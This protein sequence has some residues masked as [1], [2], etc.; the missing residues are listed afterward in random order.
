MLGS[1]YDKFRSCLRQTR[2][3]EDY[4]GFRTPMLRRD[5]WSQNQGILCIKICVVED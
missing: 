1:G 3:S 2:N 5:I 4:V